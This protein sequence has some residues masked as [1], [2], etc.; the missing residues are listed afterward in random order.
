MT[1][2]IRELPASAL[3]AVDISRRGG[4][5]YTHA[6]EEVSTSETGALV[7]KYDGTVTLDN[8]DE[9]RAA[10]KLQGKV[11]RAFSAVG[12]HSAVGILCNVE[13]IPEIEKIDQ[14]LSADVAAFNSAAQFT[15]L[16][17]TCLVFKVEGENTKVLGSMLDGLGDKLTELEAALKSL[18][19]QS[20]RQVLA[21]LGGYVEMLPTEAAEVLSNA[22][23]QAKKTA[24]VLSRGEKKLSRLDRKL[25]ELANGQNAVEALERLNAPDQTRDMKLRARAIQ[26]VIDE[27]SDT[28]DAIE[29]VKAKIDEVPISLARFVCMRQVE[30]VPE[31]TEVASEVLARFAN[32]SEPVAVADAE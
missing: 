5:H 9:Y 28:V 32:M 6:N 24:N 21:G 31:S 3:V 25:E 27:K 14:E 30:A 12:V 17:F 23:A 26:K 4:C 1:L 15:R 18:E 29:A 19:P 22:L 11:K 2:N 7:R 16:D 10:S 8:P 13:K 20:M